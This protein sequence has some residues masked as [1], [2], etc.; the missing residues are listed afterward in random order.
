MPQGGRLQVDLEEESQG[1]VLRVSDTGAGISP[2]MLARLFR[3]FASTKAT[4]TGLGL[5]ICKRIVE[6][7]GGTVHGAN[8]PRGGACFTLTLPAAAREEVHVQ[9]AGH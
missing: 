9:A 6:E 7:H 3:P 5:S 2:L 4:G 1:L 8:Q